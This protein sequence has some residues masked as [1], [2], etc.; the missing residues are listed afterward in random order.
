MGVSKIVIS[1][2]MVAL[3]TSLPELAT[4]I[5]AAIKREHDLLIG[6][7]IG[8]NIMNILLVLATSILINEINILVDYVALTLMFCSTILVYIYSVYK[9][10]FSRIVGFVFLLVYL[11]FNYAIFFNN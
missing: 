6:N 10:N 4:S 5:V 1:L 3:G 11:I 7:I 9:I 8:S 2:T